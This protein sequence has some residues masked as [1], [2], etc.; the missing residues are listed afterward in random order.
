MQYVQFHN[1]EGNAQ[2]SAEFFC[3]GPL[4]GRLK[5]S[6]DEVRLQ[7]GALFQPL[8]KKVGGIDAAGIG[9]S[10]LSVLLKKIVE[11]HKAPFKS[12]P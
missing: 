12:G 1:G 8:V 2:P 4:T 5:C 9:E 6:L 11:R 10:C 7:I 3:V